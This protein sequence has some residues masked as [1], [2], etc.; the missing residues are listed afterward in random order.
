MF[1]NVTSP[2]TL[3]LVLMATILLIFLGQEIKK[4]YVAVLPL[5]G[6]LALL[7]THTV[8]L[9]TLSSEYSYLSTTYTGCLA[10]DFI[11]VLI[12]FFAYLWVDDIEARELGKKSI[13]NSLDWFW[14]KV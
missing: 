4:S 3:F 13:D 10:I 6:H 9:L 14:K 11:F 8:Q 2:L 7:I 1:I 12:S 5:V